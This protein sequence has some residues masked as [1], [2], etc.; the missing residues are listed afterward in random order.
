VLSCNSQLLSYYAANTILIS[1]SDVTNAIRNNFG[2]H[3]IIWISFYFTSFYLSSFTVT[4]SSLVSS[5]ISLFV[6][7]SLILACCSPL[8][9][10]PLSFLRRMQMLSIAIGSNDVDLGYCCAHLKS[11]ETFIM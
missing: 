8:H 9:Y 11:I 4:S 6:S 2:R 10:L 5:S 3:N 7:L 1:Q